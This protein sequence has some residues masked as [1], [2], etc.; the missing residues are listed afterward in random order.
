MIIRNFKHFT[1]LIRLNAGIIGSEIFNKEDMFPNQSLKY[2]NFDSC[3]ESFRKNYDLLYK[4]LYS[5]SENL[6]IEYDSK[7]RVKEYKLVHIN[8]SF[9][10]SS[11]LLMFYVIL[12]ILLDDI[13]FM[14]P[15][16]FKEIISYNRCE[17]MRNS[18]RP[19]SYKSMENHF[20]TK[21]IDTDFCLLLQE[22][23][24]WTKE[25]CDIRNFLLHGFHGISVHYDMWTFS[26]FTLFYES[27]MLKEFI[28]NIATYV[29]RIY[30]KFVKFIKN[31]ESYFKQ[32]SER[33]IQSFEYFYEG[34]IT[35][36]GI[37]KIHLFYCGLGK[38][39][40]NKILIKMHPNRRKKIKQIML[41]ILDR[42]N[43]E[44]KNCNSKEYKI[45]T[46]E[47]SE[48]YVLISVTCKCNKPIVI[49]LIVEKKFYPYFMERSKI[50][51][52][53]GLLQYTLDKRKI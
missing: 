29:A 53:Y 50:D 28:P 24:S 23:S 7:K 43:I 9:E 2:R 11:N 31:L 13:A 37:N 45:N 10:L 20:T 35:A 27:Y 33:E 36:N 6:D 51:H 26:S 19:W 3:Q 16:Y 41:P 21:N 49:P 5:I 22:N 38:L 8:R 48:N 42:E 15:F 25:V 40:E 1:P 46:K 12:K 17:D 30:F 34:Y 47:T 52:N 44:C 39:L 18:V 4:T 32:R 14:I